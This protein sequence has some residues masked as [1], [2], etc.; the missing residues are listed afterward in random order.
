MRICQRCG[1]KKKSDKGIYCQPCAAHFA[2]IKGKN[3]TIK[4]AS[5]GGNKGGR[6]ARRSKKKVTLSPVGKK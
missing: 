6:S 4:M 5:K 3:T 2:G 1:D